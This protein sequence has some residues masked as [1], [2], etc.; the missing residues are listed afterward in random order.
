MSPRTKK[1]F[2]EIRKSSMEIIELAAID[3]FAHKGYANT[4]IAQIAS[5][6]GV[7]KGLLY[8]YYSGK[9]NLLKAIVTKAMGSAEHF[10]NADFLSQWTAAQT[11]DIIVKGSFEIYHSNPA[12]WKLLTSLMFQDDVLKELQPIIAQK[13]QYSYELM[14]PIFQKL[15]YPDPKSQA[16]L[17][18]SAM[19]GV[20]LYTLSVEKDDHIEVMMNYIIETFSKPYHNG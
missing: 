6:A 4:S 3:L 8:N 13:S 14:V 5:A 18:G 16:F 19:D 15:G 2:E 7:S 11:I 20:F 17:F 10:F 9:D 1:Q 12:Y